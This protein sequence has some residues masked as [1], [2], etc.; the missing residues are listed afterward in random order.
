MNIDEKLLN[1][2]SDEMKEKV[3][4][5]KTQEELEAL[6][7]DSALTDEQL[8]AVAGGTFDPSKGCCGYNGSG[9]NP[10]SPCLGYNGAGTNPTHCTRLAPIDLPR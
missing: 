10:N 2:F 6:L 1:S 9:I 3:A 7:K 5:C 4:A 8:E